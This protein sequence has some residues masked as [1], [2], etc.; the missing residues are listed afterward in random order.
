MSITT[1]FIKAVFQFFS[2]IVTELANADAILNLILHE[3]G[4]QKTVIQKYFELNGPAV[5]QSE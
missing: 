3:D 2:P 5:F 1:L 4:C